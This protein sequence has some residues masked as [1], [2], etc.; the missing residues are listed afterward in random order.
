[1]R[2]YIEVVVQGMSE[3]QWANIMPSY[4]DMLAAGMHYGRKKTVFHPKMERFVYALRESIHIIDLLKTEERL[5]EACEALKSFKDS[6]KLI[7]WV[8]S[9][10][11]SGVKIE[12]IAKEFAL[13]Y[14]LNRWLGGTLTNFKTIR[15]RINYFEQI[16]EKLKKEQSNPQMIKKERVKLEK[17]YRD[18]KER[19]DGLRS[20]IRIPEAIFITSLKEGISAAKEAKR[21]GVKTFAIVN[22]ESDPTSVDYPIPANDNAKGSVELILDT[23]RKA[24]A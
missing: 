13:P 10:K 14:V 1:M 22:T 5:K 12:E 16:E 4:D 9:T 15:S 19:F 3:I 7:L 17:Q 8:A 2:R 21:L 24:L 23:V 18:M 20:L 6:G 11:Q